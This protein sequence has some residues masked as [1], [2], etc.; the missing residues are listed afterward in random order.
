M[1]ESK[2]RRRGGIFVVLTLL[3]LLL[4]MFYFGL[5]E[6]FVRRA[7]AVTCFSE[8][9]QGLSVGS[10]V[11]FRGVR[12]G[13]VTGISILSKEKLIKVDMAIE[14]EHFKGIDDSSNADVRDRSFREFMLKEMEHGLRCRLEFHGITGMKYVTLDYFAKPGNLPGAPVEIREEGVFFIPSVS[15]TFKDIL[16][17]LTN[18]LDRISKVKFEVIF[19]EM[20]DVLR[21]LNRK[22]ADPALLQILENVRKLTQNLENSS[23]N[24]SSVL[25]KE[26]MEKLVSAFEKNLNDYNRLALQLARTTEDMKLPESSARVR[27]LG[28]AAIEIRQELAVTIM[29]L[30]ETLDELRKLCEQLNR[31][32]GFIFGGKREQK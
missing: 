29:K 20:E 8:S 4:M 11:K 28:S 26:R 13:E 2:N 23:H 10:E 22:L 21:E 25:D 17:A 15:S 3:L 30:N 16:L 7:K 9:I 1:D 31:D 19:D 14:V 12:V 5:S 18:A 27:E 6:L 24:I 32:P